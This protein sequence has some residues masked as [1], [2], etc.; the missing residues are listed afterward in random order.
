MYKL[1]IL[2]GLWMALGGYLGIKT[3]DPDAVGMYLGTTVLF[4][5]LLLIVGGIVAAEENL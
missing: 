3:T 4:G 1:V 5:V 2:A